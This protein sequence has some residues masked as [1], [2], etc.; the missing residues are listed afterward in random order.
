M[1]KYEKLEEKIMKNPY[2]TDLTISEVKTFLE[3]QGF[4]EQSI[5]G[6]HHIFIH[7]DLDYPMCIPTVNGR[8]IKPAYIKSIRDSL[9]NLTNGKDGK[10]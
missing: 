2:I 1:G 6:S 8:T 10:L 5:T 3:R 4:S 9:I 7:P